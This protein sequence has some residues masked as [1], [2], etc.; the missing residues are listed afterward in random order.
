MIWSHAD[1]ASAIV[2]FSEHV[3]MA[4]VL[5]ARRF[6]DS[7]EVVLGIPYVMSYVVFTAE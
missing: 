2:R 6:L 5:V 7:L 1:N 3:L 4:S